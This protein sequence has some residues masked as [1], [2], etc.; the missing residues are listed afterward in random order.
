VKTVSTPED[1]EVFGLR[2]RSE[3]PL[4]DL[5][6]AQG[7]A[8]Q[9]DVTITRGA[10]APPPPEAPTIWGLSGTG[11]LAVLTVDKVARFEIAAGMRIR[12]DATDDA[13]PADVRL[14]ML[15]SAFGA[16]LHQRG[17]LPLHANAIQVG[18]SAAAFMGHSGAGKS[19]MA[20]A[21]L[22]GGFTLLA[23]DVCVVVR[24]EGGAPMA[25]PGLPRLRLWRDAVEAS[26]R[27]ADD[28]E[29]AFAG[30]QK[31]VV[32]TQAVQSTR[33]VPLGRIY[34]LDKL[35]EG[36]TGQVIRRLTGVEAVSAVM[37]NI[38]RGHYLKLF[39]GS[40]RNYH[41]CL[42]LVRAVPVFSVQRQ[43]GLELMNEQIRAIAHH[44]RAGA[45]V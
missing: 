14:F 42:E 11:D 31:Y 32:P 21:F 13:D 43:W 18:E 12:V 44:A 40:A 4:P 3:I 36:E 8:A 30:Q 24:G 5:V 10:V 15:G 1:Y 38:Y 27:N 2:V 37:A 41:Q 9:A 39:G 35:P 23:D 29:V 28:L 19:T 26:G 6:Q 17:L 34:L 16:L 45:L 22:D 20:A 25:Q 33:A 7:E